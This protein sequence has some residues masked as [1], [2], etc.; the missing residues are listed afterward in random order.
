MKTIKEA[1]FKIYEAEYCEG[2]DNVS[3]YT[4]GCH[5]SDQ[6]N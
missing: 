4:G 3:S 2:C 1:D 6:N 5:T